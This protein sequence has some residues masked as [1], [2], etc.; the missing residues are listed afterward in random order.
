[1]LY[2]SLQNNDIHTIYMAI[3][4]RLQSRIFLNQR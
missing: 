3:S 1:M 2:M 4:Y